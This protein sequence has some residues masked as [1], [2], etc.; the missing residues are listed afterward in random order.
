[1]HQ[2]GKQSPLAGKV[3][4]VTAHLDSGAHED[5]RR[6]FPRWAKSKTPRCPRHPSKVMRGHRKPEPKVI[7]VGAYKAGTRMVY[8]CPI[9]G[10]NMVAIGEHA[11]YF[12]ASVL[13]LGEMSGL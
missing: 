5:K 3:A 9:L 8:K 4:Q 13:E 6:N 7:A 2:E 12:G 10:C 11:P 1:M